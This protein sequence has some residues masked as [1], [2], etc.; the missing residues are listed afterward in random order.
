MQRPARFLQQFQWTSAGAPRPDHRRDSRVD[1]LLT[2]LPHRRE[3]NFAFALGMGHHCHKSGAVFVALSASLLLAVN[4]ATVSLGESATSSSAGREIKSSAVGTAGRRWQWQVKQWFGR[5]GGFRHREGLRWMIQKWPHALSL[6][7]FMLLPNSGLRIILDDKQCNE[8][9]RYHNG[10]DDCTLYIVQNPMKAMLDHVR[11]LKED[12]VMTEFDANDGGM[13]GDG[14]NDRGIGDNGIIDGGMPETAIDG[15]DSVESSDVEIIAEH[16]IENKLV[17]SGG[18]VFKGDVRDEELYYLKKQPFGSKNAANSN[19]KGK[20]KMGAMTAVKM[21]EREGTAEGWRNLMVS[22]PP[23]SAF[24]AESY[25][26]GSQ[27]S[28]VLPSPTDSVSGPRWFVWLDITYSLYWVGHSSS[29]RTNAEFIPDRTEVQCLHRWQKVLNPELV[30][31]YWTQEEDDIIID[32]VKKHGPKKWSVIAK[33]LDGRIGKQCRERWHNHLDPQIRKE[34]WTVEEERLLVNAHHAYGNKWAE[35]AKLL[36]G[37][38]D[39][40]IKNHWNSSLKKRLDNYKTSSTLAISLHISRDCLKHAKQPTALNHIDLN[41]DPNIHLRDPPEIVGHSEH[42]SHRHTCNVKDIKSCSEFLS[43]SM[44]TAQPEI[45]WEALAAQGSA[46]ALAMQ[47]LKLDAVDD[48]GTEINFV[49]E[50][51]MGIGSLNPEAV[52]I[53][54][55]TDKMVCSGSIRPEGK[56]ANE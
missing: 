52:D 46:A 33:A 48:K 36:P 22:L 26:G 25:G 18:Y 29:E 8:L 44:P 21:E 19:E 30:K 15:D 23:P 41:K 49:C 54:R 3:G 45:P 16:E 24:K 28:P 31:G 27:M 4:R 13:E 37:R 6:P 14:D 43:L 5:V 11:L 40:S 12:N 42:A 9:L 50:K 34:A 20:A 55:V 2:P 53:G 17:D 10:K 47:G 1:T 32:M 51:G 56:T 39:N 7:V 38:T 35:I